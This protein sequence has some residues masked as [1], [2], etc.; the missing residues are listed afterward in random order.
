MTKYYRV[1]NFGPD[2][3]ESF[4]RLFTPL[5]EGA[6]YPFDES[7]SA[8][9]P[10]GVTE[11]SWEANSLWEFHGEKLAKCIKKTQESVASLALGFNRFYKNTDGL[12]FALKAIPSNVTELSLNN[13]RFYKISSNKLEKILEAIPA[14][15]TAL[16]LSNNCLPYEAGAHDT[17]AKLNTNDIANIAKTFQAVK[18]IPT[19]VTYLNLDGN[20]FDRLSGT[21][22]ASIFK[23]IPKGVTNL[24]LKRT[25]L[26]QKNS[27]ELDRALKALPGNVK[28]VIL[29]SKVINLDDLR[30]ELKE[31]MLTNLQSQLEILQDKA[32]ELLGR[33]CLLAYNAA[34][35]LYKNLVDLKDKYSNNLI[36]CEKF[37]VDSIEAIDA[38]R[39]EL[40]KQRGWKGILGNVALCILGLGIG[41]LA[42]CAYKGSFF[43]FNSDSEA[44]LNDL[45]KGITGESPSPK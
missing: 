15:V 16:Y 36:N 22:L 8:S 14:T 35:Q 24:S 13:N 11:L 45:Q 29:D 7:I 37:E 1:R 23:E 33:N 27:D 10:D 5:P 6:L 41:Y 40:E 26:S 20:V 12:A 19:S 2:F 4:T 38:A 18:A 21:A 43:H 3:N 39:P 25:G 42:A 17:S 34:D 32:N 28:S 44:K 30:S 9:M 31:K